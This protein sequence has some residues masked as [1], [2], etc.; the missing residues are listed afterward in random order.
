MSFEKH[1][2]M[3]GRDLTEVRTV[4]E[5]LLQLSLELRSPVLPGGYH[6]VPEPDFVSVEIESK[7][8][9]NIDNVGR[10]AGEHTCQCSAR[11]VKRSGFKLQLFLHIPP[12]FCES[13]V[14]TTLN[15]VSAGYR[16]GITWPQKIQEKAEVSA[17]Q[18]AVVI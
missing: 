17:T 14:Q 13:A 8:G 2:D 10:Q 3:A 11:V 9:I 4:K 12:C 16:N 15:S 7:A 5:V 1:T 6:P 18:T